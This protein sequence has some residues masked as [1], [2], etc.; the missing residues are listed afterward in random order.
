MAVDPNSKIEAWT[1]MI[2]MSDMKYPVYLRDYL[3]EYK[4]VSIGSFVWEAGMREVGY[5]KVHDVE[6]PVGDVVLEG[7]PVYNEDDELW[8]KNW[9]AR[10][11]NE[12]E[13]AGN[14]SRAKEDHRIRAYQV[15]SSDLTVGIPVGND[16]I[17]VEP[18]EM[19]NLD[20]IRAYAAAHPDETIFIRKADFTV[21]ELSAS[22][23]IAKVDEIHVATGKVQQTL[24]GYVKSVYDATV[25]TDIP[26]VPTTFVGE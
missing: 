23:A 12:E 14:L 5:F 21:M 10:D 19:I 22:D 3:E 6:V 11:F 20:A 24:L 2:R 16:I 17:S 15:F 1:P 13:L 25:I 4:N 8:Y 7:K 18:R 26:E 9:T